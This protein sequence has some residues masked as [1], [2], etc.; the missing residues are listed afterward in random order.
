MLSPQC[1]VIRADGLQ[2]H[3]RFV[4]SAL[5]FC[6]HLERD[7]QI[8]AASQHGRSSLA[9]SDYA[10]VRRRHLLAGM[11]KSEERDLALA[12]DSI[13]TIWR[14]ASGDSHGDKAAD[15]RG[16][17]ATD[18]TAPHDVEIPPEKTSPSLKS[19]RKFSLGLTMENKNSVRK[20]PMANTS[21]LCASLMQGFPPDMV[22]HGCQVVHVDWSQFCS[23]CLHKGTVPEI[24]V[25]CANGKVLRADHVIMAVPLG[26]LK[27]F[28]GSMFEPALPESK[29]AA[30]EK[31]GVG[32]VSKI[33]LHYSEPPW[34]APFHL[35]WAGRR[36]GDARYD[37]DSL[38]SRCLQISTSP[39]MLRIVEIT[40]LND[41]PPAAATDDAHVANEVSIIL[42]RLLLT[43][44][45]I[46]KGCEFVPP[47]DK[48]VRSSWGRD[49]L[50]LGSHPYLRP[51]C[52]DDEP[53]RIASPLTFRKR[54]VLQFA[55]DHTWSDFSRL[56]HG[57]RASGLR[58]AKRLT[59]FYNPYFG[60]ENINPSFCEQ[61]Y[62]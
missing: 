49:P 26:H 50:F 59:N 17:Y 48:I 15:L 5:R 16:Q 53:A 29:L 1:R 46:R 2:L 43:S 18:I 8:L 35:V 32:T 61:H 47:P 36:S 20:F 41:I 42:D 7:I 45:M 52:D 57:A 23:G 37:A 10:R 3:E 25:V 24:K 58:E 21:H 6:A 31:I 27:K 44:S 12:V 30:I 54:P 34:R 40:F 60:Y 28:A 14:F 22:K 55:G 9:Y 56:T 51:G 39:D 62:V 13:S 33:I 38:L 4:S 11:G 19:F